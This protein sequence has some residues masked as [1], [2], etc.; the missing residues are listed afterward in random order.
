MRGTRPRAGRS[1]WRVDRSD[2]LPGRARSRSTSCRA[3][4][5]EGIGPDREDVIGR[6]PR[7]SA[8]L[9]GLGSR[10]AVRPPPLAVEKRTDFARTPPGTEPSGSPGAN[11]PI[12]HPREEWSRTGSRDADPVERGVYV[13]IRKTQGRVVERFRGLASTPPRGFGLRFSREAIMKWKPLLCPYRSG[14]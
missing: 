6:T 13:M 3:S 11:A 9:P 4:A 7:G 12:A 14:R 1:G 8:S 10:G 2:E 5:G